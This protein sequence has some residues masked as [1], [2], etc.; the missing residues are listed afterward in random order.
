[1]VDVVVVKYRNKAKI[2]VKSDTLRTINANPS[3]INTITIP[4]I[5][6]HQSFITYC[7]SKIIK[8]IC[9]Y[10]YFAFT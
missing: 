7:Q 2:E 4:P 8:T 10:V 3:T 1:M 6:Q 9:I 5:L